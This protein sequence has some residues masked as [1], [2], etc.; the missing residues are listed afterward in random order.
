MIFDRWGQLVF[1]TNDARQGWDGRHKDGGDIL[2][3]GVYVWRLIARKAFTAERE[4]WF[5]TVTLLK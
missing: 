5:G 2:P 1:E 4:D 3:Q